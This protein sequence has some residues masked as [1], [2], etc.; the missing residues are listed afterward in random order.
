MQAILQSE[1]RNRLECGATTQALVPVDLVHLRRFTLGNRALELEVLQMF[2]EQA[3]LILD[4]LQQARTDKAW[5]D[6]AHTLKGSAGAI[7][8]HAVARAA[9][10]AELL[11]GDEAAWPAGVA[12]IRLALDE[13]CSFIGAGAL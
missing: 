7:G 13:A 9:A 2:A 1:R 8:A 10:E 5:R 12:R 3:P 11:R 4:R 6:A